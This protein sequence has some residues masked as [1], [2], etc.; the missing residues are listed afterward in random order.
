MKKGDSGGFEE[1]PHAK[2]STGQTAQWVEPWVRGIG[3]H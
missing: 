3:P 1:D 2:G